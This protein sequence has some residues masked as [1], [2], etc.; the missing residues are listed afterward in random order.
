MAVVVAVTV[1]LES[2]GCGGAQKHLTRAL[3]PFSPLGNLRLWIDPN[4]PAAMQVA[5]WRARGQ[6]TAAGAIERIADKPTAR[7]LTGDQPPTETAAAIV[8]S[9]ARTGAVPQLVLYDVPHRDCQNY[10]SGGASNFSGYLTWVRQVARGLG[11]NPAIVIL[12]PDAVDQAVSGCL[13]RHEASQR[14]ALLSQAVTILKRLP[15]V[16]VYL[17]AGNSA[18]LPAR[19]ILGP[20]KQSGIA[21]ADGFALNVANFQ[22]TSASISYGQTLARRLG[23]RHFIIDTSRNGNGP[24]AGN[25]PNHWCN[26]PGRALGTPPTTNTGN[27]FVDALLWIKYPGAS[28]GQCHPGDPPAGAWWPTYALSL[29]R[30]GH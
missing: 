30:S 5:V 17:D 13:P 2:A 29:A 14:Y 7:W 28:D 18:W 4:S 8:T 12:E 15:R 6:I 20:L 26:P 1:T 10:S 24:P 27:P 9:A 25:G 21:H 23:S 11:Q 3:T 16:Y 19:R 22:T